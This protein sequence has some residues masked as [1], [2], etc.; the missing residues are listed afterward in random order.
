M[1]AYQ[2]TRSVMNNQLADAQRSA[3]GKTFAG[4]GLSRGRGQR[5]LDQYRQGVAQATGENQANDTLMGDSFANQ[6]MQATNAFNRSSNQLQYDSLAEQK[7]Q[8]MWDS[9]FGKMQTAWGALAGL[10]R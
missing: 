9:R 7:R 6:G 1:I 4:Q 3:A 10:L 5:A 2:Q 8:S